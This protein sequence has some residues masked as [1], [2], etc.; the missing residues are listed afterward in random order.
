MQF[1]IFKWCGVKRKI[2]IKIN[3]SDKVFLKILR[4]GIFFFLFSIKL[5][6]RK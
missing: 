3:K 6:F 1:G 4:M 5:R 2:A